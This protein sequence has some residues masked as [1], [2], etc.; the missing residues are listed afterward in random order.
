[1]ASHRLALD[2]QKRHVA[3]DAWIVCQI[4][5]VVID[6]HVAV[7]PHHSELT[8]ES[9]CYLLQTK[10]MHPGLT[11]MVDIHLLVHPITSIQS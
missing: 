11:T 4:S 1:M 9:L 10:R 6:G 2:N 3:F 8:P 5:L 7:C